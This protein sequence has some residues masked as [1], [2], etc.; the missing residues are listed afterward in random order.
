MP[1]GAPD[2]TPRLLRYCL[3]LRYHLLLRCHLL[4]W[5]R[6]LLRRRFL[7]MYLLARY[8]LPTR[9][10]LL[11]YALLLCLRCDWS[12]LGHRLR[13]H[14]LLHLPLPANTHGPE[15]AVRFSHPTSPAGTY[16]EWPKASK[17]PRGHTMPYKKASLKRRSASSLPERSRFRF[18]GQ[19]P[20]LT[21]AFLLYNLLHART[22]TSGPT[23][24]FPLVHGP[25][26]CC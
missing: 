8:L 11:R 6:F 17:A 13:M 5:R 26:Q 25:C 14:R 2:A 10:P 22:A 4:L 16:R 23:N 21:L 1:V 7:P 9:R 3:F 18:T 24:L 12:L 15:P 20:A 19:Q